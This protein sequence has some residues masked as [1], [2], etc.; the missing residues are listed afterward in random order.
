MDYLICL[1]SYI[2]KEKAKYNYKNTGYTFS[3]DSDERWLAGLF[4]KYL[5]QFL[6]A[7]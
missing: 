3:I 1:I 2:K 4:K 6:Y 5:F 7:I